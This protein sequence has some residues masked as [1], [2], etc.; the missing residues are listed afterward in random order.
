M[1]EVCRIPQQLTEWRFILL[2]PKRKIPLGEMKGWAANREQLTYTYNDPK[3]IQHI[4]SGG[5]YGVVADIDRVIIAADTKEVEQAV[6]A[7]LPKTFTVRSPR[8]QTKHFYF[9]GKVTKPIQTKPTT[10]GDPCADIRIGNSYVLGAGSIFDGY[11]TYNVADDVPIATVTEEQI[12]AA[13]DEFII[14]HKDAKDFDE[15][16]YNK[17]KD[18]DFPII[19]VL[20]SLE[21]MTQNG[22]E[23]TGPH[24]KHGSSTGAN[25]RI[26]TTKNVWHCFRAGHESG[27][28]PLELLA[29][30][31]GIIE[32]ADC[33]KGAL[34]GKQFVDTL[35]VAKER[36]LIEIIPPAPNQ[37]DGED[38][39][40]PKMEEILDKLN[41]QYIFKTPTDTED[42]YYYVASEGIY[43]EAE[44]KLK[45]QLETWLTSKGSTHL[46]EEVLNHIKRSSFVDRSVFNKQERIIPVKNGL[47]NLVTLKLEAF[48]PEKVFTYK[49]EA[50]YDPTKQCPKFTTFI[51]QVLDKEDIPTLQEYMGYCL[52]PAMPYHKM[53]WLYGVGRNGKGRITATLRAL[54]GQERCEALNLEDLNGNNRFAV[55]RLYGKLIN[56]ASEPATNKMLQTPLLK[57][58]T[59]EDLVD[60]EIKNK[61]RPIQ[62]IN[63]AKFFVLGNRFPKVNDNTTGFWDRVLLI[64]FPTAFIGAAQVANIERTWT[65]NPEEMSGILNWMIEGLQRLLGNN[66]FTISKSTQET[67]L[68]FKRVSDTVLAFL[69]EQTEPDR[70]QYYTRTDFYDLYK[71]YCDFYGLMIEEEKAFVG[72]IKQQ[73]KIK[74]QQKRIDGKM[75]RVWIGVKVKPVNS[76]D[77]TDTTIATT[78]NEQSSFTLDNLPTEAHEAH[79]ARISNFIK[80]TEIIP[81]KINIKT[82]ASAA[83]SASLE[84][85]KPLTDYVCGR[86]C[87]NF[88]KPSCPLFFNRIPKDNPL[89]LKCYG[90]IAPSPTNEEA[91]Y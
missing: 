8:H 15:S 13:L 82:P 1:L 52:V 21:A 85:N 12:I 71:E 27:G 10:Q 87:G 41:S 32:C 33:H 34:R 23:L 22:D 5:N 74:N 19:K 29:V 65:Q 84:D 81:E 70:L 76:E 36:G 59:G 39:E 72:K 20:P 63:F 14:P 62:F 11:G 68:E 77:E 25:F 43:K 66:E 58:I 42:I 83:S 57:K 75:V 51:N 30:M 78:L 40:A 73:P 55:A 49:L 31:E 86:D 80:S 89:P 88:S 9:Y 61:Q 53:L 46:I 24:P 56:E 64:K 45:A 60:G 17:N 4:N 79:E 91:N 37:E 6:E 48:D 38:T 69:D 50:E 35:H 90:Y 67:T 28:G 26:N 18:L 47:L 7:R 54:F 16:S 2:Q 44:H 3:L